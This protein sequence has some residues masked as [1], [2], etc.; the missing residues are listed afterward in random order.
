[1]NVFDEGLLRYL[2]PEQLSKI[3]ALKIGIGGAGG[4]GSN[5]AVMLA[6][7]GFSHFEILDFDVI[8]PSNLNRQ[9]Y[10]L[11]E[12]GKPKVDIL[13]DRLL[14][15]NPE[16]RVITHKMRWNEENGQKFFTG[17][18]FIAEAFDQAIWKRDFV[19][20]YQNKT[21]YIVSGIGMAGIS[22]GRP[23]EVKK[24]GNIYFV[25]D[26]TTDSTK[27]HPPMAPR[28]TMC[29]AMMAEIIL[30]LTLQE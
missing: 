14:Q 3:R 2:K 9:Q 21:K 29:A 12:V 18:T 19:E 1:M 30:D 10:F 5:L 13:T 15:I 8:E 11:D 6:R 7:S 22:V 17:C 24:V 20:F 4:L 25:G 26:R 16:I 23:M 27:G 28:V